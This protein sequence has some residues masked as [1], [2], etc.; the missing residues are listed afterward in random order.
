MT[1][2][3]ARMRNKFS[4]EFVFHYAI[5]KT[6]DCTYHLEGNLKKWYFRGW[7]SGSR[8]TEREGNL[9][10]RWLLTE[11]KEDSEKHIDGRHDRSLWRKMYSTLGSTLIYILMAT[12][13]I[14]P[15]AST[16]TPI[17]DEWSLN[18][19]SGKILLIF[20]PGSI[21]DDVHQVILEW[22]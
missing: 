5:V 14:S 22:A 19:C 4:I 7:N 9:V 1:P 3:E 21:V 11:D 15:E 6:H 13:S 12:S 2:K 18:W 17:H 10:G 8:A 20:R 16:P